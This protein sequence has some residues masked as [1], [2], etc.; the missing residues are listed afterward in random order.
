MGEF[1]DSTR[2]PNKYPLFK[3]YNMELSERLE[4]VQRTKDI[5]EVA[6]HLAWMKKEGIDGKKKAVADSLFAE[7]VRRSAAEDVRTLLGVGMI[8]PTMAVNQHGRR[9][10]YY[11]KVKELAERVFGR[12]SITAKTA[13]QMARIYGGKI[14]GVA[15][16]SMPRVS[17]VELAR[18]AGFVRRLG[19][20]DVL[21][22]HEILKGTYVAGRIYGER[23]AL[24]GIERVGAE[25]KIFGVPRF[26]ML[27]ID[28]MV[29]PK[30]ANVESVARK[31]VPRAYMEIVGNVARHSAKETAIAGIRAGEHIRESSL[32]VGRIVNP[33]KARNWAQKALD[34]LYRKLMAMA[35][36]ESGRG[37]AEGARH[38]IHAAVKVR[39]FHVRE[40]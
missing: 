28:K 33:E 38:L 20:V 1:N 12:K 37:N 16:A 25:A 11:Q 4:R 34:D 2:Q 24:A 5:S 30:Y 22:A 7:A 15:I 21:S 17:G 39:G 29:E 13:E 6:E 40:G 8:N 14:A 36:V 26:V 27:G 3:F 9:L 35:R 23:Q 32:A 10:R 19:H 31:V 18:A